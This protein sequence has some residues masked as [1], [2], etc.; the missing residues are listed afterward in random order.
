M[1]GP[2]VLGATSERGAFSLSAWEHE[3][4][5]SMVEPDVLTSGG[6]WLSKGG[7]CP[8]SRGAGKSGGL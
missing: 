2:C 8:N 1:H 4:P 7:G 3:L 5:A 6:G